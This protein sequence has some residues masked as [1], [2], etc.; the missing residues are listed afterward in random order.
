[1]RA[2]FISY[3][4]DDAEGQAGRLFD[5]LVAHFGENHVFMDV[6]GIEPGR[7]FRKVIDENVAACGVLLA[8]VGR[9]WLDSKDEDGHRRL[10][11]ALDFVRLETASALKRDIP[12]VPVLVQGSKMP[13]ADQLPD[14]L[15]EFAYRNGVELT[16]ARWDSDL[17]LLIKALE[18]LLAQGP[19]QKTQVIPQPV[20]GQPPEKA[21]ETVA[22]PKPSP[23]PEKKPEGKFP[24]V[25]ALFVVVIVAAGSFAA[26]QYHQRSVA[27]TLQA[28]QAA[29]EAAAEKAAAAAKADADK[30]TAGKAAAERVAADEHAA[31]EAAMKQAAASKAA[32]EKA[33]AERIA[34]AQEAAAKQVAADRAAAQRADAERLATQKLAAESHGAD[35]RPSV[36]VDQATCSS[37]GNGKFKVHLAGTA[38]SPLSMDYFLYAEVLLSKNG[39]RFHPVC[40][41]WSPAQADDGTLWRVSCVHHANQLADTHWTL[42]AVI[43]P[44]DGQPPREGTV[45]LNKPDGKK[46]DGAYGDYILACQ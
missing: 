18:R 7:D 9:G 5:D 39:L 36:R 41:A 27:E 23:T 17:Q 32:A 10:D 20:S 2:I 1:M 13:R 21:N 33:E 6:A 40:S 28:K 3:R 43:A 29:E 19:L 12:V 8:I 34:A 37:M 15:K 22:P 35:A 30:A 26:Y 44:P 14:D 25:P 38:H 45:C 46:V 4:R 24:L 31:Q 42:N 11:D 16:H